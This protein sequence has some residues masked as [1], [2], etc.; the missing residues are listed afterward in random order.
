[1]IEDTNW[2]LLYEPTFWGGVVVA[3]L[4]W[5]IPT[6][7][8]RK[9]LGGSWRSWVLAPAIPFQISARNTWPFMFAAASV[10][11]AIAL[12]SIPAEVMGWEQARETVW[13]F[14]FVP[15]AFVILSFIWWPLWLSPRWYRDWAKRGGT[16]ETN[17][18][19]SPEIAAV[20]AAKP[21]KKRDRQL[22]DIERC[23]AATRKMGHDDTDSQRDTADPQEGPRP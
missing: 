1:M 4:L 9:G 23:G 13:N 15:W 19:A 16:R 20:H 22:A 6:W 3:L 18:W 21:S 10:A 12:L 5:W 14:F 8:A 7:I 2:Y 17:P 11:V